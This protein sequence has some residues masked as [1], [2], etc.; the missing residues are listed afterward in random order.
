MPPR[1]STKPE[2]LVPLYGHQALQKQMLEA[3]LRGALPASLL[4]Q[5]PRG[6]GKQRLA[7][8]LGQLLLCEQPHAG[9]CGACTQCRFSAKLAHPDL[10]WYFPRPRLKDSDPDLQ[11]VAADQAEGVAERMEAGGIYAPPPGDEAIYVATVRA[12]VQSASMSP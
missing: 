12:I 6:V 5:G 11:D 2:G 8:W 10:H 1:A 7:I 3:V 4:F 9:P